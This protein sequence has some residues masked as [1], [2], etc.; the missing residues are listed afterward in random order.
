MESIIV[1]AWI[2]VKRKL[3]I[4][5]HEQRAGLHSVVGVSVSIDYHEFVYL[6]YQ[7]HTFL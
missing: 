7:Q 6:L 1:T 2:P 3:G 5:I 4:D